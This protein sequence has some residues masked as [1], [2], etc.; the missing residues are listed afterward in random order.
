MVNLGLSCPYWSLFRLPLIMY[1]IST[2][3]GAAGNV[4]VLQPTKPAMTFCDIDPGRW[5]D[6][7]AC[8]H[9]FHHSLTG[10]WPPAKS[11]TG[12]PNF[13]MSSIPV[14]L[15]QSELFSFMDFGLNTFAQPSVRINM[16][17][18]SKPQSWPDRLLDYVLRVR[19][20]PLHNSHWQFWASVLLMSARQDD[21]GPLGN[22]CLGK[23]FKSGRER[24][25]EKKQCF[26]QILVQ[27]KMV[28]LEKQLEAAQ[29][30]LAGVRAL[31]SYEDIGQKQLK[32]LLIALCKCKDLSTSQA[33]AFLEGIDPRIWSEGA[34]E[35][36]QR[37]VAAKTSQVQ[38]DKERTKMQGFSQIPRFL[39]PELARMILEGPATSDR[40]LQ[41]LCLH[42]GRMSLRV[43]SEFTIAVFVTL[44]NW[45]QIQGGL[46]EQGKIPEQLWPLAPPALPLQGSPVALLNLLP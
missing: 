17:S 20:T 33:A 3:Q 24:W 16:R 21:M 38:V 29:R 28:V 23:T 32:G 39:T 7:P 19:Y 34:V 43:P 10:K 15:S 13:P 44:S 5:I 41:A 31:A 4:I 36:L 9:L 1:L 35:E 26:E 25:K 46:T 11:R 40:I 8:Q 6:V 2:L 45:Q 18:P 42:A 14:R 27:T 12:T 37:E 30:F 22:T